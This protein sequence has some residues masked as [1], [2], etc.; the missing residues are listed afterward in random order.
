MRHARANLNERHIGPAGYA[1][2]HGGIVE[3]LEIGLCLEKFRNSK[4][5]YLLLSSEKHGRTPRPRHRIPV[6]PPTGARLASTMLDVECA[7][8]QQLVWHWTA[9]AAGLFVSGYSIVPGIP[10][11]DRHRARTQAR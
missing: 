7:A 11:S 6:P 3:L 1:D 9:T 4:P 5:G 10:S 2:I 8:H